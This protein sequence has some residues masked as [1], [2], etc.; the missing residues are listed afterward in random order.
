[1]KQKL[2]SSRVARKR[3][4]KCRT[5]RTGSLRKSGEALELESAELFALS[6]LRRTKFLLSA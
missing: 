1:M 4:A 2:G 5:Y 3:G 6:L